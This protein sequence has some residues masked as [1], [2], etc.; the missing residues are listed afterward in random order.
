MMVHAYFHRTLAM[1]LDKMSKVSKNQFSALFVWNTVAYFSLCLGGAHACWRHTVVVLPPCL[2]VCLLPGFRGAR[3]KLSA[4]RSITCISR[5]LLELELIDF[6]IW[7][8]VLELC[9]DL[10]TSTTVA[11]NKQKS[12][13]Q[14]GHSRLLFNMTVQSVQQ[15][16]KQNVLWN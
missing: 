5:H 2:S 14:A 3:S 16:S 12:E 13:D 8:F 11:S 1:V 15:I 10:L 9:C 7:S 4:D 6:S